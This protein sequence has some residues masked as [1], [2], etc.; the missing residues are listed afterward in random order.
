MFTLLFYISTLSFQIPDFSSYKMEAYLKLKPIHY[1]LWTDGPIYYDCWWIVTEAYRMVGYRWFKINS[2]YYL[3]E[4]RCKIDPRK[5]KKWDLLINTN[6]GQW[7]VAFISENH[8]PRMYILDYVNTHRYAS[9]RYHS[10][11]SWVEVMSK[12]CMLNQK[13]WIKK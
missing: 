9:Y 2:H 11:Y 8:Y 7:H 12:D 6:L 3:M 5:A 13:Y 4:T 10:I 1:K